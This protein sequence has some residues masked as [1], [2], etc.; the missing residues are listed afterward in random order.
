MAGVQVTLSIKDDGSA[1]IARVSGEMRKLESAA[2]SGA[3]NMDRAFT[4]IKENWIGLT[5]AATGLYFGLQKVWSLAD[6]AAT[7]EETISRLNFQLAAH[8]SEASELI[9]IMQQLTNGQLSLA[10]AAK[11]ASAGLAAGLNVDQIKRFTEFAEAASDVM[12]TDIPASFDRM[13]QAMASGRTGMLKQL[14]IVVDL[15]QEVQRL[16]VSARSAAQ[17]ELDKKAIDAAAAVEMDKLAAATGRYA[18]ILSDH[19][20]QVI[21]SRIE[22]EHLKKI[23]DEYKASLSDQEKIQIMVTA[24]SAQMEGAL[25]RISDGTMSTADRMAAFK[26]QLEDLQLV[27]GMGI[28]AAGQSF[29]ATMQLASSG[30]MTLTAKIAYAVGWWERWITGAKEINPVIQ[31]TIEALDNTAFDLAGKAAENFRGSLDQLQR[32]LHPTTEALKSTS[33]AAADLSANMQANAHVQD[34]LRSKS[35]QTTEALIQQANA[36]GRVST[37]TETMSNAGEPGN[38]NG[39]VGGYSFGMLGPAM[40]LQLASGGMIVGGNSSD[41]QSNLQFWSDKLQQAMAEKQVLTDRLRPENWIGTIGATYTAPQGVTNMNALNSQIDLI[42]NNL[43]KAQS[44]L[45]VNVTMNGMSM[46]DQGSIQTLVRDY[47]AP[48][49]RQTSVAAGAGF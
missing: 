14:G 3:S 13:V 31:R 43:A 8:G 42:R 36:M 46:I 33:G 4:K 44:Q 21:R 1:T 9:P 35:Q 24:A 18:L 22:A 41:P 48:V 28:S 7:F 39:V 23:T 38:S 16:A 32:A 12:G 27:M 25:R 40:D 26:A 11:M 30:L 10:S 2:T 15:D 45:N 20:K 19:E 6:N 37:A 49:I 5:A 47:L 34:F 29:W 17:V